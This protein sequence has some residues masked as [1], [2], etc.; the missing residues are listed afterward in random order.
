MSGRPDVPE[1]WKKEFPPE[2]FET[3]IARQLAYH[4]AEI[5]AGSRQGLAPGML[6]TLFSGKYGA[7][8]LRVIGVTAGTAVVE[9][10]Y[11]DPPLTKG[12]RVVSRLR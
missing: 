7:T 1:E 6:L 8:D 3:R 10:A 5:D 12:T 9:N 2:T 11:G 4:R